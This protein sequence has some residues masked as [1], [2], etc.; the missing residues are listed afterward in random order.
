PPAEP[1]GSGGG[2]VL[3]GAQPRGDRQGD[4]RERPGVRLDPLRPRRG[5]G[6][7]RACYP[8]E[9]P[10]KSGRASARCRASGAI[11]TCVG[12]ATRRGGGW[13]FLGY[14]TVAVESGL[15]PEETSPMTEQ[16]LYDAGGILVTNE[17]VVAGRRTHDLAE[18]T[19][20]FWGVD[21]RLR[22]VT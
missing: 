13:L 2:V 19:T 3:R 11:D 15:W 10:G 20:V 18:V 12:L 5:G 6:L 17:R 4:R 9:H 14:L 1:G 22:V 16:V 21:E 8:V 7:E